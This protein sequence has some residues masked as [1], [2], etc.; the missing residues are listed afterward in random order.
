MA[1]AR[2]SQDRLVEQA[3]EFLGLDFSEG[4]ARLRQVD[5]AHLVRAHEAH[6]EGLAVGRADR[7]ERVGRALPH[8]VE[9]QRRHDLAGLGVEDRHRAVVDPAA[10]ELG[11]RDVEAGDDVDE[12]G[13]L[14]IGRA[15]HLVHVDAAGWQADRVEALRA[16]RI[17][18]IDDARVVGV[19]RRPDG[20]QIG[21]EERLGLGRLEGGEER[22]ARHGEAGPRSASSPC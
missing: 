1:S 12:A 4:V 20:E 5:E 9:E 13:P 8:L 22:L 14:P 21:D 3:G 17:V 16:G 2:R 6:G 19:R 18:E 7:G 11:R 15:G 10:L